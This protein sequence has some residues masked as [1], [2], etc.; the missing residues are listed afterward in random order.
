[1]DTKE[2]II[3]G[4]DVTLFFD[5]TDNESAALVNPS[6]FGLTHRTPAG[7]ETTYTYGT[8]GNVTRPATGKFEVK[9][10]LTGAGTHR[11][12]ATTTGPNKT[13][14]WQLYAEPKTLA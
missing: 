10:T 2:P 7:V 13:Q 5:V 8:D 12:R 4:D 9:L 6:A 1:M 14:K 11:G 3:D